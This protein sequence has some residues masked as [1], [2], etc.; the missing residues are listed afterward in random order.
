MEFDAFVLPMSFG[1]QRLWFLDQVAPNRTLYNLCAFVPLAF[2][3]DATVLERSVNEV[4]R[5]HET[6]RT[7]FRAID[8]QPMQIVAPELR[9]PLLFTDLGGFAE[10]EVEAR[11]LALQDAAREFDLSRGPLLRPH[12]MRL[13]PSADNLVLTMHHIVSDGWS[14]GVLMRELWTLYGAFCAGQRSPLPELPIQYGDFA[15]WQRN[16]LTGEVRQ[17]QLDYWKH[18]LAGVTLLQLPTDRPRPT[19]QTFSGATFPVKLRRSVADEVRSLS[20]REGATVFMTLLAAFQA[21]LSRHSGQE[22]VVVGSPIA[23]RNRAELEGLIGFFV[24]SLVLRGN[25]SGDPTF[26]ELL[27][28][29]RETALGA[30]A[31]QDVPFEMLLEELQ[32]ERDLSRNPIF[33][34]MF[35]VFHNPAPAQPEEPE[36]P[37]AAESPPKLDGNRLAVF[38]LGLH[39]WDDTRSIHGCFEYSTILFNADTIQRLAARFKN[40]LAAAV[41]DPDQRVSRLPLMDAAERH[42]VEVAWNDTAR[43]F[44]LD[45]P[46][47][48]FVEDQVERTPECIAVVAGDSQITFRERNLPANGLPTR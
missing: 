15:V 22:D 5:R 2:A 28:R 4:I 3:V 14:M 1:Q 30:F 43:E 26:R 24:N 11:R 46:V 47:H 18:Q 32:I 10:P 34:V 17:K 21:L 7:T 19:V 20:G 9:L 44:P 48:H 12:L 39:L 23:G 40:L 27:A 38:D 13:G 45:R 37:A 16:W 8:G 35:Q 25:L 33:Q 6:L 36:E 41:A 42:Q 31:H 29:V